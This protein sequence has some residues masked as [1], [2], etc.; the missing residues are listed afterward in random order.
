MKFIR[1][2]FL[3]IMLL[4]S[5][6]LLVYILL[7]GPCGSP[8]EY[9]L[10]TLDARFGIS[11]T[12]FLA[13]MADAEEIWEKAAGKELFVYSEEGSLPINLIYD[14]RQEVADRNKGLENRIDETKDT[15]DS[16]KA[17]F[18]SLKARHEAGQAEYE[19]MIA[20][21]ERAQNSYNT[22][23]TYWNEQGGAP[24]N[25]FQKL[26]NDRVELKRLQGIL[27]AKRIEVNALGDQVNLL[28]KKYN[29]LVRAVNSNI[30]TINL[31]ADKEFEQGEYIAKGGSEEINVYEFTTKEQL[32]RVIL[33][34]FGHALGIDH[35]DNPDSV[36]YYLNEAEGLVLSP[37]DVRDLKAVC[38]IK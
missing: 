23:V 28:I 7:K 33:H 9:S 14:E 20:A 10:G 18:E 13:I 32:S 5:C 16:V 8:V 30:D 37:E 25:E 26:E 29:S 15:A 17:Q 36:M 31:S 21:F 22:K 38:R 24:K 1:K 4:A 19:S 2:S 35:N 34:E 12:D 27:E 11:K 3:W 6:T